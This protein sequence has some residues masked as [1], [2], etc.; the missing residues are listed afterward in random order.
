MVEFVTDSPTWLTPLKQKIQVLTRRH[1]FWSSLILGG[2]GALSMPPLQWW[3]FLPVAF[4]GFLLVLERVER[5]TTAFWAGWL[6]GFGYYLGGLYWLGN[7]PRTLGMWFAVPFAVIGLPLLLAIYTALVSLLTFH[8]AKNSISRAFAFAAFWSA[9]EW[10]KG[11]LFTG[12]PWNM[13]GYAWDMDMLQITSV[14]GIY[15]L[16]AITVLAAVIF[17]TRRPKWIIGLMACMGTLQLWG[18]YRL[19]Q[20]SGLTQAVPVQGAPKAVNLRIVQASIPQQ[21]KW[22]AHHF[23]VNLDRYTALSHLAAEK[24]LTAVIW[25][26]SSVPM[27]VEHSPILLQKLSEAA[28]AGGMVIFGAP[29]EAEGKLHTS[30]IAVNDEGVVTGAYDKAHL[31]PFGEYM[32]FRSLISFQKLTYGDTD[33]VSGSGIKTLFLPGLPPV[34]PLICYEAIFPGAVVK[35]NDRPYWML[36]ITNDAWFGHSSGPWQHLL[37]VQVRAIEEGI[38]LI[39]AANNGISAVIDAWGQILYRLELDEV[40]FIDFS[41]PAPLPNSTFYHRWGDKPFLGLIALMIALAFFYRNC[42]ASS[43]VLHKSKA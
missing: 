34:S 38:P 6:F 1:Y 20:V 30:M 18:D 27:L 14:I 4:S 21:N 25:P 29:R 28:P 32:P 10:V 5:S 39:R 13:P 8:F 24:P 35:Q 15:G 42:Q 23:Q 11:H 3:L 41:L 31:V 33:Y 2:I 26:E 22:L 17:V 37:S 7:A 16:T 12:F 36:N 19:T 43:L 9:M 40:G